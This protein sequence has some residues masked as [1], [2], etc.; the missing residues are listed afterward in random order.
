MTEHLDLGFRPKDK[1]EGTIPLPAYLVEM[2]RE[3]R[4]RYP[5]TRLV[6]PTSTGKPDQG[7]RIWNC[8]E[9]AVTLSS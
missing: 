4:N 6:F 9:P 2:L 5:H 8:G 7:N 1:E 3:R